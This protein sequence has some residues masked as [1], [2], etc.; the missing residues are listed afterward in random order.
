[1]NNSFKIFGSVGR[2]IYWPPTPQN[3]PN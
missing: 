1:M 2:H 3:I